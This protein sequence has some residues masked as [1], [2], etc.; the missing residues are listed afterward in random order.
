MFTST[1]ILN[2]NILILTFLLFYMQKLKIQIIL[3]QTISSIFYFYFH[4]V[5]LMEVKEY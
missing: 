5:I 3:K 2:F 1:Y 4:L